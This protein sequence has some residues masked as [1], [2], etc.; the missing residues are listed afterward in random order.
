[1]QFNNDR[2][3][4]TNNKYSTAYADGTKTALLVGDSVKAVSSLKVRWLFCLNLQL[5]KLTRLDDTKAEWTYA[6]Y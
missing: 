5:M 4:Q 6:I 3:S 1:M 2:I